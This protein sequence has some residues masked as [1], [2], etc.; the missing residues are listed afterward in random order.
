MI[1]QPEYEPF[2]AAAEDLDMSVCFHEGAGAGMP[3]V[4]TDRFEGSRRAAHRFAHNGNDD[5]L[6]RGDLGR[7][8]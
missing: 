5:G 3:Q 2:W 4:G 6:P 7:R 8:V 1:D